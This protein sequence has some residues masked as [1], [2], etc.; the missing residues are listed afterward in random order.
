VPEGGLGPAGE[1]IPV[2]IIDKAPS[3]ELRP[4]Q[5]DQDS[6]PPYPVLDDILSMM[7]EDELPIA[8]IVAR[9]QGRYDLAL[10]KRV[11]RL[12]YLAE[13]KRRQAPPGV[14]VTRKAFGLGRKY[15]VTNG[16]RD[17]SGAAGPGATVINIA[18]QGVE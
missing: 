16:Y 10:V 15:P 12:V 3:A 6:L 14:K 4:D 18:T 9:G 2:A 8:E 17:E 11:E 13:Y 5:K 7:V 1:V